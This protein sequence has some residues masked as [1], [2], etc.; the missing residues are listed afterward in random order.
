MRIVA[1]TGK[2]GGAISGLLSDADVR[3]CVPD[4]RMARIQEIHL[5]IIHC[6][7]DGIDVAL[8]GGDAE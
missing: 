1:L 5:L 8:F 2:G 7:C 3:V 6:L 4:D